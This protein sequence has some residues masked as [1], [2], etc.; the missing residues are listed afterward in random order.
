MESELVPGPCVPGMNLESVPG[1][2]V[3]GSRAKYA[4]IFLGLLLEELTH[5]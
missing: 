5:G 2:S 1:P 3:P 4:R